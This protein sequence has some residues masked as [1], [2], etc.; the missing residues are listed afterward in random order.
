MTCEL[1][2]RDAGERDM[3]KPCCAARHIERATRDDIARLIA[4]FSHKYGHDSAELRKR[5]KVLR[6]QQM[7]GREDAPR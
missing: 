7:Q 6:R 4:Q 5:I 1:C 3:R 2:D